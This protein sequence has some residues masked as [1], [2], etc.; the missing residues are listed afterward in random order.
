MITIRTSYTWPV[1]GPETSSSVAGLTGS[2]ANQVQGLQNAQW[3]ANVL[4]QQPC[5]GG[6]AMGGFS[7]TP[8]TGG[9]A[10]GGAGGGVSGGGPAPGAPGGGVPGG[11][12]SPGG[13]TSPGGGGGTGGAGVAPGGGGNG[14]RGGGSGAGGPGSAGPGTPAPGGPGA[15]GG[16]GPV[17]GFDP[18]VCSD[19]VGGGTGPGDKASCMSQC[20]LNQATCCVQNQ[21]PSPGCPNGIC[22]SPPGALGQTGGGQAP[23]LMTSMLTSIGGL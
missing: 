8:Y 16:A 23:N 9:A 14:G 13:G 21:S 10:S 6:A 1:F 3:L 11:G 4:G 20:M 22:P 15:P 7:V 18:P 17:G 5:A 12:S 2:A 19:R